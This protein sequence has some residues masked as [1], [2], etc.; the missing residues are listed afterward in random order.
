MHQ[1]NRVRESNLVKQS[2]KIGDYR[3]RPDLEYHK[4][5]HQPGKE[6]VL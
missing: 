4:I 1:E 3:I 2:R 5:D 6:S